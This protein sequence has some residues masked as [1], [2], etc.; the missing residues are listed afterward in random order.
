MFIQIKPYILVKNFDFKNINQFIKVL[1]TCF[2]KINLV[3]MAK[4]KLYQPY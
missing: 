2:D 3:G 1:K 4:H